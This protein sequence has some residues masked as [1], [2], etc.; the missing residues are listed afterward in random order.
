MSS[1]PAR[2]LFW[3]PWMVVL[4]SAGLLGSNGNGGCQSITPEDIEGH[5]R[6]VFFPLLRTT[7]DLPQSYLAESSLKAELD[8]IYGSGD[9]SQRIDTGEFIEFDSMTFDGPADIMADYDLYALSVSARVNLDMYMGMKGIE[10][11]VGLGAQQLRLELQSAGISESDETLTVGP[12]LGLQYTF[13]PYSWL[14]LYAR[15][16]LT[17]GFG[18]NT[19][20]LVLGEGGIAVSPFPHLALVGGWRWIGY[21]EDLGNEAEVDLRLSGPMAG[22]HLDF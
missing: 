12:L 7:V 18:R 13:D 15:G 9:S 21:G 8:F 10:A 20:T 5:D 17:A 16:S 14:D 1:K 4:L 19:T 2:K 6:D 22:I 3:M 11:I